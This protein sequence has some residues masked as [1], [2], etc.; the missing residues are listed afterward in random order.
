MNTLESLRKRVQ[1]ELDWLAAGALEAH[2]G[3]GSGYF[4]VAEFEAVT[5]TVQAIG[6]E[7]LRLGRV[8]IFEVCNAGGFMV[9]GEA[10]VLLSRVLR[11]LERPDS[12]K[13]YLSVQEAA[14][15]TGVSPKTIY[16]SI[17]R[18]TLRAANVAAGKGRPTFR[19]ARS[20]LMAERELVQPVPQAEQRRIK[21]RHFKE[22]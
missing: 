9:H 22:L 7:A 18:G 2:A 3:G 6:L 10:A 12:S 4:D 16:R 8:E 21:S 17:A 19:I 15:L 11:M 14:A 13:P 5:E 20:D 1:R